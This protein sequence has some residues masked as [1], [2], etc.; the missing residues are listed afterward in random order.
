MAPNSLLHQATVGNRGRNIAHSDGRT[1]VAP[2][3]HAVHDE[4]PAHGVAVGRNGYTDAVIAQEN[5]EVAVYAGDPV[6]L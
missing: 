6:G 3:H 4:T 5:V 1:R 2:E